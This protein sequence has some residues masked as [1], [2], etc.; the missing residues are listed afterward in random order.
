MQKGNWCLGKAFYLGN[1]AFINQVD[2]GDEW[3]VIRNALPFESITVKYFSFD[4]F[5]EFY[6]RIIKASDE[7]LKKLE[8]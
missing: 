5:T 3:L 6:K 8:Y 1:I 7:Q 2:G 4:E